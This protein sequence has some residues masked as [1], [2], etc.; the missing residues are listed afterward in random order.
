[1]VLLITWAAAVY[2]G[3]EGH[4]WEAVRIWSSL[5]VTVGVWGLLKIVAQSRE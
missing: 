5:C 1:M 3:R 2:V 4:Q